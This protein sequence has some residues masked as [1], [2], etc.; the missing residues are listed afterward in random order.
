MFLLKGFRVKVIII[1]GDNMEQNHNLKW[2]ILIIIVGIVFFALY[3]TIGFPKEYDG[4]IIWFCAIILVILAIA[5]LIEKKPSFDPDKI[6]ASSKTIMTKFKE[7]K[8]ISR[9]DSSPSYYIITSWLNP[10]DNKLYFFTSSD[11]GYDATENIKATGIEEF[12][13]TYEAGNIENYMMDVNK[14]KEVHNEKTR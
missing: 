3:H 13:I 11:I 12:P 8:T 2:I 4:Y 5:V 10:G 9:R 1:I 14:V 7:V 6:E